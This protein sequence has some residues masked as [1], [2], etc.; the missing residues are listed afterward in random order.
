MAISFPTSPLVYQVYTYNGITYI[1]TGKEWTVYVV[2]NYDNS[3]NKVQIDGKEQFDAFS[4]RDINFQGVNLTIFSSDTNTLVFSASSSSSTFT[5]GTVSGPT[6]FT[7]GL[8]TNTI[9]ATTYYNLPPSTFSGGTIT[10]PS[11]FTAGLTANTISATTYYNLPK[12]VFVTGGTYSSGTAT[13]TNNT[14]GTFSVTGFSTSTGT[15]FTGGTVSGS[16]N[17]TGG[18]TAD[19]IS[20]TTYY[21]LPKDVFV[22]GGTYTS[23]NAIFTNNT[24]GTFTVSG[25]ATGGGGGQIFY[26]NLSQSKNSNRYLSSTASTSSEQSTGVTINSGVTATISSFQSD[27]LNVILIPGGVWTFHLH[28][29]KDDSNASFNIFVDVYKKT[30]GGTSTLLFTTES[31]PVISTSPT[32]S[33]EI[34]DAY[35]S[36]CPLVV[37]DSI[38]AVVKA[39]N[40]SDQSYTITLF[41]EGSQNYSYVISTLQTQQGLTCETISDCSIIQT[42]QNNV[43]NKYDKS[44]GTISGS[45]II[46]SGLTANTITISTTPTL[47]YT[48]SQ[49][50][51]RNTTSGNVEYIPINQVKTNGTNLYL[52]YNY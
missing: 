44:G 21:N 36:G 48:S 8:N 52:F 41:S 20:A 31:V 43:S 24:G 15:S 51:T 32:T 25:F 34:S 5:G 1:W 37:S 42:I 16:T 35:F 7:A 13:F 19:T 30:S 4:Y 10:G 50:L 6:N 14:G 46:Q 26:L 17:F 38:V 40:T 39:T 3:F 47:N 29:Y 12:D 49:V 18:L 45:T 27:Q 11:N 22:T 28:S 9:S 23:G 2:K 33:M